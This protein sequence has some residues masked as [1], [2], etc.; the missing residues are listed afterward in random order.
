MKVNS[1]GTVNLNGTVEKKTKQRENFIFASNIIHVCHTQAHP[2]NELGSQMKRFWELDSIGISNKEKQPYNYFE[3]N[4]CK[5][6]EICYEMKRAFKENYPL[7]HDNFQM[8]KEQL[9]KLHKK[10]KNDPEILSHNNEIFEEQRRLGIIET[11]SEPGKKG[12]TH[13]L[14]HHPVI[15]QD[16]VTTKL[17]IVFDASAKTLGPSLNECL[18]KGPQLTH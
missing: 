5:N 8:C 18:Y 6:Q 12:E 16:K 1:N 4:I 10:L 11:V 9:L 2:L 14:A 3:D 7:I 15:R 13:Y 17:R